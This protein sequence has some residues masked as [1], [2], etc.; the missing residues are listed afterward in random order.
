MAI[1]ICTLVGHI[2]PNPECFLQREQDFV[3]ENWFGKLASNELG[4]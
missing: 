1:S 4:K 2:K 3:P